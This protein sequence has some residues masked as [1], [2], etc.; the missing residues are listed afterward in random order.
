MNVHT[1]LNGEA[2]HSPGTGQHDVS[3]VD[4]TNSFGDGVFETL[5]VNG[6]QV[7]LLQR[8]IDRLSVSVLQLGLVDG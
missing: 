5:F 3:L 4:R 8:H 2:L 1:W 6:G 7:H